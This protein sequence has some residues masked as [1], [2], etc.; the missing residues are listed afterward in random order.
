MAADATVMPSLIAGLD[1]AWLARG[2]EE[3][4]EPDLPIC[5]PHHH[6]WD[7]EGNRYLLTDFLRDLDGGHNV[8]STVYLECGSF[9]RPAGPPE[10]RSTGEAAF[11]AGVGAMSDSGRY[12]P[13]RV[14]AACVGFADLTLGGRVEP[15]LGALQAAADGRFRGVRHAAAWDPG[16]VIASSHG[17]PV[18]ELYRRPD[19]HE[20]VAVLG[21]M[22]LTFDAWVYHPQL[23]DVADLARAF[24]EQ[25]I[26]LNHVGGPIG[27]GP[28]AGR[29]DEVFAAWS[30]GIWNLAACPNVHVKL[31][32]LGSKRA[33]FGW[34][35]R[36]EPPTSRDL[37]DAWRPYVETCIEAFGS[38]RCMFESNFPV[39]KVSCSFAAMWNAFKLIV[40]GADADEKAALFR[41]TAE[42]FYRIS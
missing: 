7:R 40:S 27:I 28:Y 17:R 42:R 26:V 12:G 39:D 30:A 20:G 37:A 31:G 23:G 5:D 10:F 36:P 16:F 41:G 35:E 13:T 29:S 4:L 6:L 32:G 21:R 9:Y 8:V 11:V 18:P 22:G 34:H 2:R 3:I 25:P 15:V 19:F 14:A 33:G 38:S 24:P 1:E